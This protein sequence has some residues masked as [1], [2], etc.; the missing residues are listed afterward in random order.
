MLNSDNIEIVVTKLTVHGTKVRLL[1]FLKS[2]FFQFYKG[3]FELYAVENGIQGSP[4]HVSPS[5]HNYYLSHGPTQR[6]WKFEY[7]CDAREV[8][9]LWFKVK[10][11]TAELKTSY[12]FMPL[13][14]IHAELMEYIKDRVKIIYHE[15]QWYFSEVEEKKPEKEI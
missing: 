15:N 1:G 6:F 5:T 10:F 12:Y 11:D 9:N 13:I 8:Q 3:S 14:P 4:I 2:V 7:E